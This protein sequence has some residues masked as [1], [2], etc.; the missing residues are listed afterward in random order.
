MSVECGSNRDNRKWYQR[1]FTIRQEDEWNTKR[2]SIDLY[3]VH[4]STMDNINFGAE[5]YFDFDGVI[6]AASIPYLRIWIGK[7]F[8]HRFSNKFYRRTKA[9]K[10]RYK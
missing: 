10:E 9:Q 8:H 2:F 6:L 4:I 5:L 3:L 7:K 1:I